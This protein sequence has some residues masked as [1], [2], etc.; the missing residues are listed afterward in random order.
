MRSIVIE[1][2]LRRL[3]VVIVTLILAAG[4]SSDGP[5]KAPPFGRSDTLFTKKVSFAV[6]DD[7]DKGD[8]LAEVAKD[9]ALMK[10]LGIDT[11][12]T[13]FGWDDYEP[14][15]G[16][17]DF[18]WLK[19]FVALAAKNGIKLR[20]YIGYTPKW[21]GKP[22]ADKEDWNNAPAD[23][24][25][26]YNFVYNLVRALQPYGNVISYEIYNEEN[27][28]LWWDGS[29]DEYMET[30]KTGYLAVKAVDPRL[31]VLIGGFVFPDANWMYAITRAG[32]ARYYDIAA[33]HAYPETWSEP[34]TAVENYLD[35]RYR[36]Y[37][38][39][40]DK[41]LGEH[42]PIWINEMGFATTPGK[43]ERQQAEWWARAVSTFLAD[44]QIEH[45]GVYEIKDRTP[46]TKVIGDAPNYYLGLTYKDRKEKLA[47]ST[48]KMLSSLL[49]TEK[50]TVADADAAVTVV[51]GRQGNLYHHL[52]RRPDGKQVLFVYDKAAA[53]AVDVALKRPGKTAYRYDLSG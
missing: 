47:F 51:G 41:K 35:E 26:W 6:L 46:E 3:A 28:R 5:A 4:L 31:D 44:P 40:Y 8:D 23:P 49:N 48:V 36:D 42:E 39:A 37:F 14:Q 30:L 16:Q 24:R 32:Y 20:P 52:F 50:L 9:F 45:I 19:R 22:G 29:I 25:D 17:Y 1:P 53:P 13:S 33:F 18:D 27:A 43:S 12:R 2:A 10:Q 15:R 7:Y 21:A 34:G 38:V 11:M